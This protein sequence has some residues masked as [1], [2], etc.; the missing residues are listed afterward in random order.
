MCDKMVLI[1]FEQLVLC[2]RTKLILC[3]YTK[4]CEAAPAAR[5][6]STCDDYLNPTCDPIASRTLDRP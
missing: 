1:I 4:F 6:L 5:F 2:S 3:G